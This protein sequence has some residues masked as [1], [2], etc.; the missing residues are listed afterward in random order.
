MDSWV[1]SIVG[2]TSRHIRPTS[3]LRAGPLLKAYQ[4]PGHLEVVSYRITLRYNVI[5]P[6]CDMIGPGRAVRA[7]PV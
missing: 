3:N 1:E 5:I 7:S 6:G 4:L 2:S